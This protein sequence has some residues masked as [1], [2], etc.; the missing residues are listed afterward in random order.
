MFTAR[1]EL[2]VEIQFRLILVLK[3]YIYIQ[4]Y[5]FLLSEGQTDEAWEPYKWQRS[6]RSRG[7]LYR[8]VVSLFVFVI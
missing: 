2:N 7:I 6:F 1:Y 8:N 4:M 5:M 3:F